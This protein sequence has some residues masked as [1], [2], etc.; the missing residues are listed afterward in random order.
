MSLSLD[1]IIEAAK[2]EDRAKST[3]GTNKPVGTIKVTV[4]GLTLFSNPVWPESTSDDKVKNELNDLCLADKDKAA[5]V[6]TALLKKATVEVTGRSTCEAE[7]LAD[8]LK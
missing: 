5:K 7:S 1:Q 4:A 2:S 6:I 3:S 8:L